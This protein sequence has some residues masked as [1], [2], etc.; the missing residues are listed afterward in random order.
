MNK[1]R[2]ELTPEQ[3]E[4]AK[5]LQDALAHYKSEVNPKITQQEIADACGWE[6]QGAVS[7]FINGKIKLNLTALLRFSNFFGVSP[8]SISPTL[9]KEINKELNDDSDYVVSNS[10][11]KNRYNILGKNTVIEFTSLSGTVRLIPVLTRKEVVE[12]IK[13]NLP[14]PSDKDPL[15]YAADKCSPKTF[16]MIVEGNAMHSPLTGDGIAHG[17]VVFV[18]P[19]VPAYEGAWVVAVDTRYDVAI[20][21]SYS[22]STGIKKLVYINPKHDPMEILDSTVILGSVIYIGVRPPVLPPPP[23]L[24]SDKNKK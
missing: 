12:C 14:I 8:E 15:P 16:A 24:N 20:L 17:S 5:R 10:L 19:K 23:Q 21:G 2:P 7:Q 6:T 3:K 22:E 1:K 18:D 9:S 4:D 11:H 13:N